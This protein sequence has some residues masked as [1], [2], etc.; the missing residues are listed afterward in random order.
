MG[1]LLS[2]VIPA[3]NEEANIE[4]TAKT[5]LAIAD[6]AVIP[7]E[8]VFVSDGSKDDTFDKIK[9]VSRMDARVRGI[10]FSRN[11]GKEAAIL[12]G[13]ATG[14]GDCFVVM[15]CDLQHPPQTIVEMYRLWLE[16]YEVIEGVKRS[17]GKE[18]GLYRKL[19][20]LFYGVLT[21]LTGFNMHNTSDFKLID[22]KV[23]Q[24]LLQMP[25]RKTFFRAMTFWTGFKSCQIE[26]D[27][28]QRVAGETKWSSGALIR[29]AVHN[30]ISFSSSPLTIVTYI[31]VISLIVSFVLSIQT[32]VRWI[33]GSAIEGFT[34]V[35][36]LLLIIGG[37]ILIGLGL[38]GQYIAAIYEEVKQRPRYIISKD[39]HGGDNGE[40]R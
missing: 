28:A 10:E 2:I 9:R 22:K 31:G 35:I 36:L 11:F 30:I 4:N 21:K 6:E 34:T 13:L 33:S 37:C 25:E 1:K 24:V 23:A 18:S 7:C 17:R 16:G 8:I 38:I 26:Y 29:Y 19:S 20:N 39:T 14:N 15:D 12:A 3:Y 40:E 5:V 32:L 27:V